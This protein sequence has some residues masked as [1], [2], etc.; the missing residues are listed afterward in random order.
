M[1]ISRSDKLTAWDGPK[2]QA[3]RAR[4]AA[5]VFRWHFLLDASPSMIPHKRD[6]LRAYNLYLGWLQQHADP[7]GLHSLQC[8]SGTLG[9]AMETPIGTAPVLTETFYRPEDGNGTALYNAVGEVC[10]QATGTGQHILV[11]FTDGEDCALEPRWT[12]AKVHTL[13]TTLQEADGWLCVFLGAMETALQEAGRMGFLPGNTLSF[14][15]DQIP[16]AFR[17]LQKATQKYLNAGKAERK[18]LAAGGIF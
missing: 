4:H 10:T 17:D 16:Q 2:Q 8:F 15:A 1:P 12:A 13:L 14:P 9:K 7:M 18:L 3:W 11:L 5:S 6:L